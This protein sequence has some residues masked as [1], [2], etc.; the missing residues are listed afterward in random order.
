MGGGAS[1]E[2][3]HTHQ[4]F[5]HVTDSHFQEL[6]SSK[7]AREHLFT[8]IAKYPV[9]GKVDKKDSITLEKLAAYFTDNSNALYPGF[10][11]NVDTLNAAF[12]YSIDNFKQRQST[13]KKKNVPKKEKVAGKTEPK[14]TK[15]MF[16]GFLPTLLLFVRVWDVFEAADKLVVEDQRVFKGEFMRIK[17]KLNHVHGIVILGET[18]D[19]EWEKEFA[20]LDK[21]NDRF[22]TFEE[23]CSYALN[24]IKRPFDYTP[25]DDELLLEEDEVDDEEDA[26]HGEPSFVEVI[27]L[28]VSTLAPEAAESAAEDGPSLLK[29]ET[30]VSLLDEEFAVKAAVEGTAEVE[31]GG[32]ASEPVAAAEEAEPSEGAIMFV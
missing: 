27:G 23:M 1:I 20:L 16:H 24:H 6:L 3:K 22:I 26:P 13:K 2:I 8:D 32:D 7:K 11:V 18:S 14:L 21:N 4:S 5:I 31:G 28:T 30:V 10:H 15:A 29:V 19:E 25:E 17:E 12:K 9:G